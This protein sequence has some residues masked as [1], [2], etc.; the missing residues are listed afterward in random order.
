MIIDQSNRDYILQKM[1]GFY[2]WHPE[3][4]IREKKRKLFVQYRF[5]PFTNR[6]NV[7]VK[8]EGKRGKICYHMRYYQLHEVAAML[9][10]RNMKIIDVYGDYRGEKYSLF[11][12]RIIVVACKEK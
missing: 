8:L 6:I 11:S 2:G 3:I 4:I 9:K 12:P 10:R 1:G 5:D 7:E